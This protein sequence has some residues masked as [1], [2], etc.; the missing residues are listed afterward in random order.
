M[1]RNEISLHEMKVYRVFTTNPD[2]WVTNTEVSM[3]SGV[4]P[5]TARA[6][7]FKLVALGILDQA[8]VFPAHR[9]RLSTKAA[10]R[11]KSYMQRLEQSAAVFGF[12]S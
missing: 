9:F 6:H 12:T 4:A 11:N 5:R 7:T 1:E 10:K 8:E 3:R 2:Q